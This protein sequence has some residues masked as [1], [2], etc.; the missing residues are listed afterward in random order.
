MSRPLVGSL[1]GRTPPEGNV[2][3]GTRALLVALFAL[4]ACNFVPTTPC[5]TTEQCGEDGLCDPELKECVIRE[6]CDPECATGFEQCVRG[7]CREIYT[8]IAIVKPANGKAGDPT[9]IAADL[10]EAAG[11]IE[12]QPPTTLAFSVTPLTEAHRLRERRP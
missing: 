6:R 10:I 5:E 1:R 11:R 2:R 7:S 8:G 12:D 9:T 3:I 4:S